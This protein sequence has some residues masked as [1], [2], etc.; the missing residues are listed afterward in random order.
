M[1]TSHDTSVTFRLAGSKQALIL[2]PVVVNGRGPYSFVLD[3]PYCFA[4]VIPS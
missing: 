3:S 2:L 1:Q 4:Q